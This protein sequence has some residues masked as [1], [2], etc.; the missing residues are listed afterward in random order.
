MPENEEIHQDELETPGID[1]QEN[2]EG[3]QLPGDLPDDFTEP[4]DESDEDDNI[5]YDLDLTRL[6]ENPT[7]EDVAKLWKQQQQGVQKQILRAQREAEEA[8]T[9]V[10]QFE[11]ALQDP[12]IGATVLGR[13]GYVPKPAEQ[14]PEKPDFASMYQYPSEAELAEKQWEAQQELGSTKAKIEFL[15]RSLSELLHE[16]EVGAIATDVASKVKAANLGFE[17]SPTEIIEASKRFPDIWKKNPSEAVELH[18]HKK[19]IEHTR[20]AVAKGTKA[21][22][23]ST[24]NSSTGVVPG[25]KTKNPLERN[26]EDY[27]RDITSG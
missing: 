19:I 27:L 26:M 6:P 25:A 24:I 14:A 12:E 5:L 10:A 15:E 8:R 17:P 7:K 1:E 21:A 23:R 9:Q 18:L 22:Q 2:Q 4:G 3:E 11:A 13:F 20:V 16:R